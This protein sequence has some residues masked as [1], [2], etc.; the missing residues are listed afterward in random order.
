MTTLPPIRTTTARRHRTRRLLAIAFLSLV[1]ET[2]LAH[3]NLAIG[4]FYAGLLQPIFHFDALLPIVV[5]ALW[6]T[7]LGAAEVWRLPLFFMT[8]AVAGGIAATLELQ[9]D[10]AV[11]APRIAMLVLGLL[12]ATRLKLP[13][14]AALVL[15]VVTGIAHGYAAVFSERETVQR[16]VLYLIGVG[17]GI[18]LISF[19]L[20]SLVLRFPA[21][22][23]QIAVRVLGSW[24]AAIGLLVTV[25]EAT[26]AD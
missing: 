11:W 22:W 1:P 3:G 17:S 18:G 12:V 23:M 19:H 16:P 4:D 2:A 5:V 24:V 26:G 7:Q 20:E 25:L 9:V 13:A 14:A 8:A 6:A 10:T 15:V 21:F